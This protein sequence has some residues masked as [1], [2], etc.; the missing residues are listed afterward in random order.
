ML[1]QLR[2]YTLLDLLGPSE[3]H[4]QTSWTR[5][6]LLRTDRWPG[7][8]QTVGA[9]RLLGACPQTPEILRFEPATWK[10]RTGTIR[11]LAFAKGG[12]RGPVPPMPTIRPNSVRLYHAT[13]S[14]RRNLGVW[15]GALVVLHIFIRDLSSR[16]T[17]TH[18][19]GLRFSAF[20]ASSRKCRLICGP[21]GE[22]AATSRP[23][24]RPVPAGSPQSDKRAAGPCLPPRRGRKSKERTG[25][26]PLMGCLPSEM[27]RTTRALPQR[28]SANL[29]SHPQ[30]LCTSRSQRSGTSPTSLALPPR[31]SD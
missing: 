10:F 1:G 7:Q 18:P 5:P 28:R 16:R 24:S 21:P 3:G 6:R 23:A 30:H 4:S 20:R 29:W 31:S 14:K 27:C 2:T 25:I 26:A 13:G 22:S 15:G 19:R 11:S 17:L 9:G 8:G 12:P